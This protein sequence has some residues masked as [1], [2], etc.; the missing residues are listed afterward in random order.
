MIARP[1]DEPGM[2]RGG[3]RIEGR[4]SDVEGR[5][6][7]SVE[8]VECNVVYRVSDEKL[9][10]GTSMFNIDIAKRN[11]PMMLQS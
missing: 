4:G 10:I 1:Q 8:D 6:S 7:C 3:G 9:V 2:D 11:R 5:A